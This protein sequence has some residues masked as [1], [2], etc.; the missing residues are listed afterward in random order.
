MSNSNNIFKSL[1][2]IAIISFFALTPLIWLCNFLYYRG[3]EDEK[4]RLV[5]IQENLLNEMEDFQTKLTPTSYI[6]CVFDELKTSFGTNYDPNSYRPLFYT[7]DE[8]ILDKTYLEKANYYLIENHALKPIVSAFKNFDKKP[9]IISSL[10][11]FNN[12]KEAEN[13]ADAILSYFIAIHKKQDKDDFANSFFHDHLS[14]FSNIPTA[15][16]KSAS[17]FSGKFGDQLSIQIFNTYPVATNKPNYEAADYFCF[18][19]SDI[20]HEL[21]LKNA[22]RTQ[23]DSYINR[24]FLI[25]K[26]KKQIKL[27]TFLTIG[28]KYCYLSEFPN[29]HYSYAKNLSIKSSELSSN[30]LMFINNNCLAT[31]ID[32]SELES[33]YSIDLAITQNFLRIAIMILWI[34][35]VNSILNRNKAEIGL[36]SKLRMAVALA[37]VFPLI[38]FIFVFNQ[39]KNKNLSL[40]ISDCNQ[41]IEQRFKLFEKILE[42]NDRRLIIDSQKYKKAFSDLY[43]SFSSSNK[44]L[45]NTYGTRQF[46]G[47]EYISETRILDKNVNILGFTNYRHL[48][49]NP[50]DSLG[51]Y[52]IFSE[53]KL[54]NNTKEALQNKA[55][56]DL[57]LG[58]TLDYWNAVST[59]KRISAESLLDSNLNHLTF[60]KKT[61]F[62]LLAEANNPNK[63]EAMTFNLFSSP[64][65]TV[66]K[67]K[68]LYEESKKLF[69]DT[70][71]NSNIDYCIFFRDK[72]NLSK[73]IAQNVTNNERMFQHALKTLFN[74]SSQIEIINDKNEYLVK[75][76]LFCAN[77]PIIITADATIYKP[78]FSFADTLTLPLILLAYS[79]IS[80]S[81]LSKALSESFLS[82]IKSLIQFVN[83]IKSFNYDTKV[84]IE[85][86]DELTELSRSFNIMAKELSKREKM[87]RFVS[88][89]LYSILKKDTDAPMNETTVTILASDIRN[90]TLISEANT[91][92]SVVSLLN[93]YFTSMEEAI[94]ANGGIIEKFIGDALIAAFYPNENLEKTSIRAAKAAVHMKK[95]LL[96]FNQERQKKN[97]L[98]IENGIGLATGNIIMGFAGQKSRRREFILFGEVLEQ[99]EEIEALTKTGKHTKIFVDKITANLISH[100]FNL[101]SLKE[102]P[103]VLEIK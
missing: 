98:T 36:T 27:P 89:N 49:L 77:L 30:V 87:R 66:S 22:L 90:F 57:F 55:K 50:A 63:I 26:N 61:T 82:P 59:N 35:F 74:R 96:L 37:I 6:D 97:M 58:L 34:I 9:S 46:P 7:N 12:N 95:N 17:F 76:S 32:I 60:L 92:E 86:G 8:D 64:E 102:N 13:F 23:N 65:Y 10:P 16:G 40:E 101:V 88:E 38:G 84:V 78:G 47:S 72:N 20:K 100:S 71:K 44:F 42:D 28:N 69:Q 4:S 99:A 62:Q 56:M 52:K 39:I 45:E 48:N 91:P 75:S 93:D 29:A 67:I 21:L 103:E 68:K 43:F 14:L 53:L 3:I 25:I 83:Q 24:Q 54:P 19:S 81:L 2:N 41:R 94:V 51:Y 73:I 5:A 1:K 15:S 85:T 79:I 70:H 18:N 11:I 33:K 80:M 31:T